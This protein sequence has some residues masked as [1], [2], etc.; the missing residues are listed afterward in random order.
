MLI[1]KWP[2]FSFVDEATLYDAL[3][4]LAKELGEDFE[5]H[6]VEGGSKKVCLN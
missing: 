1:H 4:L 6:I 5:G 3:D 2:I